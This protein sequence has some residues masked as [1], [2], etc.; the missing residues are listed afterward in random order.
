MLNHLYVFI[1]LRFDY[2]LSVFPSVFPGPDML[3]TIIKE[4]RIH[5]RGTADIIQRHNSE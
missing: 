3:K 1:D 2:S 4:R 5:T